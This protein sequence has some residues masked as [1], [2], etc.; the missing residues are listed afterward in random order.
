M[1]KG[2][3]GEEGTVPKGL[4]PT[5]GREAGGAAGRA[6]VISQWR[7]RRHREAIEADRV[8]VPPA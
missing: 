5:G 4:T 2:G 8:P 3:V 6:P 7:R 1:G